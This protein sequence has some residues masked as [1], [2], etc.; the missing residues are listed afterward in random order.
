MSRSGRC[1]S[2]ANSL[3]FFR[4]GGRRAG[5]G[6][7]GEGGG[8]AVIAAVAFER[9][10]VCPPPYRFLSRGLSLASPPRGRSPPRARKRRATRSSSAGA[11]RCRHHQVSRRRRMSGAV[12]SARGP[13]PVAS[14]K[15]D[16]R[17]ALSSPLWCR[18]LRVRGCAL[19][20][21]P[22]A[23]ALRSA[24]RARPLHSRDTGGALAARSSSNG[25]LLPGAW[26]LAQRSHLS[27]MEDV[28]RRPRTRRG[29]VAFVAEWEI[30]SAHF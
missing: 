5:G 15:S 18:G 24:L 17:R 7:R 8:E 4:Q 28:A 2:P 19:R 27:A 12:C 23:D 10:R 3:V 30:A 29:R 21:T 13:S 25:C 14:G 16:R 26:P 11:K 1:L 20:L 22:L 9:G 6:E